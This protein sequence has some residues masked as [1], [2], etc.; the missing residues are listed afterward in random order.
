MYLQLRVREL[1]CI[2]FEGICPEDELVKLGSERKEM[3]KR[4]DALADVVAKTIGIDPRSTTDRNFYN[5]FIKN[6]RQHMSRDEVLGRDV[7]TMY[8]ISSRRSALDFMML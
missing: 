8:V 3:M 6:L 1:P 5:V 2:L 7:V 4:H